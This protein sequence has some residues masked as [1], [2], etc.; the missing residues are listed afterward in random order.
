MIKS[1]LSTSR[2]RRRLADALNQLSATRPPSRYFKRLVFVLTILLLMIGQ[3]GALAETPTSAFDSANRL[4]E[5]GKFDE[6]AASFEKL[7]QAGFVSEA[8][9]FNWGNALFKAGRIGRALAAYQQAEKLS[10]RDPDVRANLQFARNQVQG[11]TLLPHRIF[12]W[13]GN[14]SLNE[15]TWLAAASVWI[16]LAVL[17]LSQARPVLR[18]T[19][20]PYAIWLGVLTAALWALF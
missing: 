16:W 4:Y 1:L 20:R 11:P 18:A 15:W 8:L 3:I 6:A 12:R 13:L 2:E 9:Y 14:L 17:T 19:L 7:V 5:Q 10:P